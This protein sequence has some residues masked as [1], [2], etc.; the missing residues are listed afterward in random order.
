MAKLQ[1]LLA[2]ETKRVE[3]QAEADAESENASSTMGGFDGDSVD[4]CSSGGVLPRVQSKTPFMME[5]AIFMLINFY[6]CYVIFSSR[7]LGR[8]PTLGSRAVVRGMG[9]GQK[10]KVPRLENVFRATGPKG[11]KDLR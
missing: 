8:G 1:D 9:R 5:G 6:H 11:G 10:P 2:S 3:A 7:H 4:V